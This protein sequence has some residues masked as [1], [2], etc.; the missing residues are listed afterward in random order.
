MAFAI[1]G[2]IFLGIIWG[3]VVSRGFRIFA[4]LSAVAGVIIIMG[5]NDRAEKQKATDGAAAQAASERHKARQTELWSKVPANQVDLRNPQ[6]SPAKYGDG[7][8]ELT[9]SIKNL[10]N[11]QLG[12]FEIDVTA[13]DCPVNEKCEVVGHS[14]EVFWAETPPQQ[15]RGI[16]GKINFLNFPQLRGKLTPQFIVKRVYAGDMLDEWDIEGRK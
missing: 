12:A 16:S 7:E 2:L 15:V 4:G 3:L 11:Q 10:S 6:L 13:R 1:F 8:F 9:G 5:A 14:T